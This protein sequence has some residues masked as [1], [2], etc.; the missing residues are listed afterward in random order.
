[1]ESDF[2]GLAMQFKDG[3]IAGWQAMLAPHKSLLRLA[4]AL[5]E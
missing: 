3:F 4:A 1:M 5:R 2:S